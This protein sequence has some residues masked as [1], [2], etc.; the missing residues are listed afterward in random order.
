MP[1]YIIW[2]CWKIM[3]NMFGYEVYKSFLWLI[4][5]SWMEVFWCGN[6]EN[7]PCEFLWHMNPIYRHFKFTM[8]FEDTGSLPF[9]DVMVTNRSH[10]ILETER[11]QKRHQQIDGVGALR[12]GCNNTDNNVTPFLTNGHLTGLIIHFTFP[13]IS[14]LLPSPQLPTNQIFHQIIYPTLGSYLYSPST[15][16]SAIFHR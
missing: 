5:N 3:L 6:T 8:E 13:Y 1:W 4:Y 9:L 7:K 10:E 12:G 2:Y 15:M 11:L 16:V 14:P